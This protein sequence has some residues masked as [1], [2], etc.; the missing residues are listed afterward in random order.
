MPSPTE[1][2]DIRRFHLHDRIGSGGFGD[3]YRATLISKGG[4]ERPVAI[5]VLHKDLAPNSQALERLR[6]EG[7][8]LGMLQHPAIVKVIDLVELDKRAALVTE[9]VEG[10]DLGMC[11][12]HGPMPHRA[13]MEV[14]SHVASALDAAWNTRGSGGK[15][16]NLIHRD[17]KPEN[18][19]IGKHGDVKLLD[20]GIAKAGGF[21]REAR[22]EHGDVIGSYRYMAPERLNKKHGDSPE[23]DV[24]SIGA[25]VFEGLAG[26]RLFKGGDLRAQ[27]A[28]AGDDGMHDAFMRKRI[29]ALSPSPTLRALL[30]AVLAYDPR[31]RPSSAKMAALC[32]DLADAQP[33]ANLRQ[34]CRRWEWPPEDHAPGPL[35][36]RTIVEAAVPAMPSE[37]RSNITLMV[38]DEEPTLE[39]R[40]PPNLPE[41]PMPARR[42]P[43]PPAP[44]P[45]PGP[46]KPMRGT[47]HGL[48]EPGMEISGKRI[49]TEPPVERSKLGAQT[50]SEG[51]GR[52][53]VMLG[54]AT[55]G[56]V[57]VLGA[58]GVGVLGAMAWFSLNRE[59]PAVAPS[60]PV[61]VAA[62]VQ[63]EP[64]PEPAPVEVEEPEV[65]EAAPPA[66]E[67]AGAAEPA[68]VVE[69]VV[70]TPAGG[71]LLVN[72]K[73]PVQ[74]RK[75]EE[76]F[77]D[78]AVPSGAYQV[79]ANW[80]EGFEVVQPE[81]VVVLDG[82]QVSV[83]C[84]S[85]KR[86]CE[87]SVAEAE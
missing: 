13:L 17:V 20:F 1:A 39:M 72:S 21:N 11:F 65:V 71:S 47:L 79:Y 55:L 35:T 68:E 14:A 49:A 60:A 24:Y 33:G 56:V 28:L 77:L 19:R 53:E 84:N 81:P 38:F 36:G 76:R 78:G 83:R 26:K 73:V 67:P 66:P 50:P 22:T 15:S 10:T 29:D 25:V 8:M 42:S 16:L 5:K 27:V 64:V 41:T 37:K 2:S 31:L 54:L 87:V 7:K 63:V 59:A 52:F 85:L 32:D 12:K 18:I 30:L 34:W 23:G 74:L 61:E 57:G 48:L 75:G 44:G 69:P 40:K 86:E 9:Y 51:G 62:P 43:E 3:V 70:A 4:V 6:D 45:D 80:G 82:T 46:T 58:A